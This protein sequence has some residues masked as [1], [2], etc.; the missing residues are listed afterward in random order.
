M[1]HKHGPRTR[2][3]KRKRL[4]SFWIGWPGMVFIRTAAKARA[5]LATGAD[6]RA[7]HHEVI[8]SYLRSGR[9]FGV[10]YPVIEGELKA[11]RPV[12][13]RRGT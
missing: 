10:R 6:R 8:R 11:N 1:S 5:F 12:D 4:F 3:T 9:K 7:S 2:N 13:T